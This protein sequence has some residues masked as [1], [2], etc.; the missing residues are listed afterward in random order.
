MTLNGEWSE[1]SVVVMAAFGILTEYS[2]SIYRPSFRASSE[3]STT[4]SKYKSASS[5][6]CWS[7]VEE[8]EQIFVGK[9]EAT[10][11][12]TMKLNGD[13]EDSCRC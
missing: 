5:R 2:T 9:I 7:N 11:F 3:Y 4:A 12:K 1:I 8:G 13:S 6:Y 10:S